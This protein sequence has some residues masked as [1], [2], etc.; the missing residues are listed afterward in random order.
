M[1]I[2]KVVFAIASIFLV[3]TTILPAP[4]KA[5]E[6]Q[7]NFILNDTWL[8]GWGRQS[9][10]IYGSSPANYLRFW[11]NG[12]DAGAWTTTGLG[13]NTDAPTNA[14]SV[15]GNAN[16]T[17]YFQL[18]TIL[19]TTLSALNLPIGAEFQAV[20]ANGKFLAICISTGGV[21][22]S[23]LLSD[24]VTPCYGLTF[25]GPTLGTDSVYAAMSTGTLSS[26]LTLTDAILNGNGGSDGSSYTNT[27]S[28]INGTAVTP[29]SAANMADFNTA[30][31]F[32][33][34]MAC[35]STISTPPDGTVLTPGVICV[36][37][38]MTES[39]A[40]I[41]LNGTPSSVFVI[42]AGSGGS[43]ALT[44]TSF[45][46]NLAGGQ[47]AKNVYFW[48]HDAA[49]FTDS[50]INGN[51]LSAASLTLTR[52]VYVGSYLSEGTVTV[53]GLAATVSVAPN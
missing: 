40:S 15:V 29:I 45:T 11:V 53:T 2:K 24:M 18:G 32:I 25:T 3:A 46:V 27:R 5:G 17:G 8:L 31:S 7:E 10:G 50:H 51:V 37:G 28:T 23:V 47:K 30:Y 19:N 42:K 16:V 33:S 14:L 35:G 4:A 48:A 38:A 21:G 39:N 36:V 6:P 34:N 22:G 52:G 20:D 26:S 1:K 13:I 49:T 44:G 9:V 43:G 41:T 12:V